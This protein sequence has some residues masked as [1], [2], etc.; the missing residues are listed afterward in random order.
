M[1]NKLITYEEIIK[2]ELISKTKVKTY[3]KS[4]KEIK[5][6]FDEKPELMTE[7]ERDHLLELKPLDKDWYL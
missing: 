2:H 1:N 6:A 7:K 3:Y 5:E 4:R